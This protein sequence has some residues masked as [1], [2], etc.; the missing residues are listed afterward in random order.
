MARKNYNRGPPKVRGRIHAMCDISEAEGDETDDDA[1]D[2]GKEGDEES[3][4]WCSADHISG[5]DDS[6]DDEEDFGE[7]FDESS[8]DSS[9]SDEDNIDNNKNLNDGN[10]GGEGTMYTQPPSN[11]KDASCGE[12]VDSLVT[13]NDTK[14]NMPIQVLS[15]HG[16]NSLVCKNGADCKKSS[17]KVII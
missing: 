13:L 2:T 8:D 17:N 12:L 11:D 5:E 7:L 16:D 15:N 6:D 4:D 9:N 14:A 10:Q 1:E 3:S